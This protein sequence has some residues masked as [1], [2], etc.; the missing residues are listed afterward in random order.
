MLDELQIRGIGVI[1][2]ASL[3]LAPGF[4]VVTG[5]TG[6][7]K[8]MLITALQLLL[9]ARADAGLVRA[10][11]DN[12]LVEARIAPVPVALVDEGWVGEGDE[13]VVSREIAAPDQDGARSRARIGGRLATV[14]TLNETLGRWV[15]VHAQ[16]EHVRLARPEVQRALLDRYAGDE[17]AALLSDYRGRFERW[18]EARE[19][20]DRIRRDAR[21]RARE[22]DRISREVREID[23]AGLDPEEDGRLEELLGRMEN[24]EQL[25]A[26]AMEAAGALEEQ[27]AAGPLGVAVSALRR[28]ADHDPELA[29][30]LERAEGLA[31]ETQDLRATLRRYAETVEVDPSELERLR[32]R[33]RT[34]AEL[35]RK[36]GADITEILEYAEQ[37]RARL[38]ELTAEEGALEDLS[39]E[40]E[41]LGGELA[42]LADELHDSRVAAGERMAEAVHRHLAE[43][44][45]PDARFA[46]EV[47]AT[48]EPGRDGAD[49]VTYQLAP[50]PGEPA[51][52]LAEAASGGERSRVA[53]AVEVVLADAEEA[54]V[55]VFDEVDAGIGGAAA[56]SV[57]EKLARLATGGGSPRQ[58]L[59][60]TH[61]PQIA[62]FADVHHVVEKGVRDGRTLTS[63]RRVDD[64]ARA[65]EL[66]RMLSGRTDREVALAHARQLLEE[67]ATRVG[68]VSSEPAAR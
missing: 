31:A 4:T 55:L 12:A 47:E 21:E 52:G 36:Y 58:V 29:E 28:A 1:D 24:A 10:G 42:E 14:T 49:R 43:L 18:T 48:G 66:A 15:E 26:A 5:E 11:V 30:L 17:H 20:L 39:E 22:V 65:E 38:E 41:A 45:M 53:L 33:R 8:T 51:R 34:I 59:C 64:D 67:A 56:M 57:G 60:V 25:V 50:N 2:E 7:G 35:S 37:A 32:A 46:V 3:A 6:A 44:A 16:G 63:V 40:V 61:L 54:R 19:R 13:L 62:A 23:A 68:S 27:G 9:G